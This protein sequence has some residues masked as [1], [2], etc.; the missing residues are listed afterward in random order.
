MR[1]ILG[2]VLQIQ[3][4]AWAVVTF[5]IVVVVAVTV[6]VSLY[7]NQSHRFAEKLNAEQT[8]RIDS[9]RL[10]REQNDYTLCERIDGVLNITRAVV[11]TAFT[12]TV[13]I[14]AQQVAKLPATTRRL[15]EELAPVLEDSSRA[16]TVTK[17]H[18]LDQIP[19]GADCGPAPPGVVPTTTPPTTAP[20]SG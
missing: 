18:V 15:L 5:V 20:R 10:Q 8:S 4:R 17:A 13:T 19:D 3:V 14:T 7:G 1:R 16:T 9:G 11:D 6:G 2:T 12:G